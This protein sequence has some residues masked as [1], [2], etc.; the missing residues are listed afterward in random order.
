MKTSDVNTEPVMLPQKVVDLFEAALKKPD[1]IDDKV[2]DQFPRAGSKNGSGIP[3]S[4]SDNE[5]NHNNPNRGEKRGF[6]RSLGLDLEGQLA[7][8]QK[9]D[10]N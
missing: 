1:W 9:V 3:L 2:P 7:K 5:A 6:G 4:R 10:E 8:R